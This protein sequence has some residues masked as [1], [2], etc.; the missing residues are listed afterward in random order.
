MPKEYREGIKVFV[1]YSRKDTSLRD[2]LASH[3]TALRWRGVIQDW[4]DEQIEA[5]TDWTKAIASY[6]DSARHYSFI[7]ES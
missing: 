4:N 7:T 1:S 6:L 5:G 2:E 3:L